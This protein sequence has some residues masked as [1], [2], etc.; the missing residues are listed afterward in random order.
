NATSARYRDGY[1]RITGRSL[2]EWPG[3]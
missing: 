1:E 3:A 2:D